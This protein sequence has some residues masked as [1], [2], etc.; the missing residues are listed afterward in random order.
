[1][2]PFQMVVSD[3]FP[4]CAGFVAVTVL[5]EVARLVA[6]MIV[7]LA[8]LLGGR[9]VTMTVLVQIAGLVTGMVVMLAG[10]FFC[11]D[12]SPHIVHSHNGS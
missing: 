11:H 6:G 7:M 9:L 3:L 1:M 5:V 8:R 12:G 10:C 2:R 4:G